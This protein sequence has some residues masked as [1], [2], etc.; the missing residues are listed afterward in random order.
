MLHRDQQEPA[1]LDLRQEPKHFLLYHKSASWTIWSGKNIKRGRNLGSSI[2]K[3]PWETFSTFFLLFHFTSMHKN[4]KMI[5]CS[6]KKCCDITL[7]RTAT[8]E[9]SIFK[10]IIIIFSWLKVNEDVAQP[11]CRQRAVFTNFR[12]KLNSRTS[13]GENSINLQLLVLLCSQGRWGLAFWIFSFIL[14]GGLFL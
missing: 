3:N 13:C 12:I 11:S 2:S 4:N 5:D 10:L 1:Q 6:R 7:P 8:A 14:V 9:G